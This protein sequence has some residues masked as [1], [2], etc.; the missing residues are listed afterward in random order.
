MECSLQSPWLIGER[1]PG[2]Q[3]PEEYAQMGWKGY[4]GGIDTAVEE[5][6]GLEI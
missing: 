1:R 6:S 2:Q 5:H 3:G 4:P